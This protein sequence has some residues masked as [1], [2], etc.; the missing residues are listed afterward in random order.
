[1]LT[2]YY[3]D[4]DGDLYSLILMK[5]LIPRRSNLVEPAAYPPPTFKRL[6]RP[7]T[8]DDGRDFFFEYCLSD[9]LGLLPDVLCR[10]SYI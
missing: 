7:P 3:S 8:I 9:V 5:D 2:L 10:L 1:L 4:L 6:D